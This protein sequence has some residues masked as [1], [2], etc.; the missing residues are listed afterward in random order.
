MEIARHVFETYFEDTPNPLVRHHLDSYADMLNTKIPN[1]IKG[2]N[3]LQLTLA[4][5]RT[6]KVFIGGRAGDKIKYLPPVDEDNKAILPHSC[7]LDNTTYSMDIQGTV[8]IEY[9]SGKEVEIRTFENVKIA[10]L[11]LMLKSSLCYLSTMTAP[12]LYDSGECKFE[13]GGYFVIGGAEKVL[14]TQE[15][16]GDNMFYASKRVSKAADEGSRG[17][18]EKEVA[19]KIED[20]TKG[21]KFEYIGAM[22]S[23]SEDGTKGPYSHFIII[24]PKN[25]KPSDPD[26]ISKTADLSS[27]S[28]KR[29]ALITLPKFTQSVP[30]IS[31]FYALG[32]TNDQDIYDTILAGIPE[33]DRSVYDEIFMELILSHDAYLSSEMRKESDQNQDANMLVLRRQHRTRTNAGVYMNIYSDMFPHCERREGE[34]PPALYRRKAYLLGIMTRM[35]MDVALGIKPKSDRDHYRYKR[36]DASGDLIFYEFRRIYK[37][38]SKRMMKELDVRI[39]FQQKEYAGIKIRELVS[40]E[41]VDAFYWQHYAFI[42]ALE[43]SF[44]GKWGNMDGVSQELSRLGYIGT[45]AHL[46]RVNLQMDK[47]LKVVEPRR[48]HG[49]SWGML[50]PVDNP[51][52]GGIGMTKS[53]TLLSTISTASPSSDVLNIVSKF[54]N[55]IPITTIHPSTWNPT[56]TKVFINSDLVGVFSGSAETYH[57]D[58]LELRRS[59]KM[60]KFVSLCWNRF[61]NEYIIFTD[62]GRM[63]R[64]VYR[65]GVKADAVVRISKWLDMDTKLVDYIDAQESESLR[66]N[67]E[68]FSP[69]RPSEIHCTI[70]FSAT[71]SVLPHSDHNPA[72]RNAFSCQQAKQ[73]CS[74]FNTAFN[75]RF[76]TIATWLNYAQRPLSQTWTTSAVLGKNGCIGYGENV[77]VALSVYSGYN[78]EDSILI[79][80]GSLTRGMFQ[81]TY[82]HSYDIEEEMI[83]PAAKI[84]TEMANVGADP[85]YRETVVRKEGYNYD[86]LDG[87]GIIIQGKEIDDKTVLVGIV[88]PVTNASGQVTGYR[89]K[90]YTPKRGQHGIIDAVYRYVTREGIRAVKIRIAEKRVPVLGDK[91]AAR[92]G[93]KG[94][95]GL[96]VAEEDM[97]FTASGLRPDL[98]VNPHAFP[99]RMTVGQF[100]ETMTTKLGLHTGCL[101][102]STAFSTK[103]R[104]FEVRDMLD[105]IGLHPYGHEI[106]YNGQTGEMMES[107][108]FMGPTYYLRIKQMVEDKI[109]YRATGPKKLLTHQP[110]EGR[111]NDGGLR[112]GEMERDGLVSHGV[113]RFLNESLMERS[114]KSEVLFQPE[115]GYLDSTAELEGTVLSTPYALGLI[116]RE[117]ESMHISVK[118]AA[119]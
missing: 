14:L 62:A 115:T 19:I 23:V 75:K 22:R 105:K 41:N 99:S 2:S 21:E 118:L 43:R 86:L 33:S 84:H 111:A 95:C 39:H 102:D 28:K 108:I 57:S 71:G 47:G 27:F 34:T 101:V 80:E 116:I 3:P 7:R 20:A 82:Y 10:N 42:N 1:F 91:F 30:L 104:V 4:D 13:L 110:V 63:S 37:E 92:H 83:N 38:V 112:I 54:P 64:P 94:T 18:V 16:L 81:T 97:P 45:V 90:S 59:R 107:E 25:D 31:V 65:E 6:I 103:N 5:D 109:N 67:M 93:Q 74:W 85:R 17:L 106:L 32:L 46:R 36:H 114:D 53:M 61:D 117:L 26:I 29:L 100:L 12:E 76:D 48:I 98:I 66:I 68:P 77:I 9:T 56:W 58:L 87:D 50:C 78:Q 88:V 79:N 73:A 52:G 11:P 35:A 55:F 51:D 119:P 40:V 24:P 89:D 44:K 96:R 60:V 49:S 69:T 70:M 113:S 72:T 8:E 15:R